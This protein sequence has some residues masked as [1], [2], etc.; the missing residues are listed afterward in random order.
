MIKVLRAGMHVINVDETEITKSDFRR[1][2]WR[3]PGTTNSMAN[4]IISP[5]ISVIAGI[6]NHGNIYIALLQVNT[7]TD[8]IQM[9]LTALAMK[10]DEERPDWRKNTVI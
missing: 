6:S 9:Y 3:I 5:R 1:R 10:L 7:K 8:V 2:K 4:P